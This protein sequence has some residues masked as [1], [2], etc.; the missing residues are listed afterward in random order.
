[1]FCLGFVQS[2]SIFGHFVHSTLYWPKLGPIN[3]QYLS[4]HCPKKLSLRLS[5]SWLKELFERLHFL[6]SFPLAGTMHTEGDQ[7]RVAKKYFIPHLFNICP[8]FGLNGQWPGPFCGQS[9]PTQCQCHPSM[10]RRWW[11]M[12]TF[13]A[14]FTQ[15]TKNKEGKVNHSHPSSKFFVMVS[16][17]PTFGMNWNELISISV[18]IT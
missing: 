12:S 14:P 8:S 3:V 4:K 10:S 15:P 5:Q 13:I 17:T 1:M 6:A 11:P 9:L 16:C 7:Y 18:N 2:L